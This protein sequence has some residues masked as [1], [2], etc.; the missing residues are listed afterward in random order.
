MFHPAPFLN[1]QYSNAKS[2]FEKRCWINPA[3]FDY[4]LPKD[5][6]AFEPANPRDSARLFVYDTAT[7]T[8]TQ[9]TFLSLPEFLPRDSFLVMNET[10]VLPARVCLS[11]AAGK[12]VNVLFLLNE[13]CEQGI[14]HG[15]VDRKLN[16]GKKVWADEAYAFEVTAH[17]GSIFSFR[18]LFAFEKLSEFFTR[19]GSTPIPPYLQPSTLLEA[20]LRERYQTV[21]ARRDGSIA[22][23]TAS[24]HFTERVFKKCD[25]L[26]IP[27]SLLTLHVGRGTFAPLT[28]EQLASGRLHEEWYEISSNTVEQLRQFKAEGRSLTAVGTTSV[29]SL[30]SF[31]KSGNLKGATDLFI[32]PGFEFQMVDSLI[33]NFHVPKSS[34]MMLVQA[35]LQHK[36]AKR[37]ILQLYEV[38]IAEK[39]RFYSFGDSML[40]L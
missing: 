17:E 9:S 5:L 12:P 2:F 32:R 21:F 7:D 15:L 13:P 6:L 26:S 35:F 22:A 4:E 39:F 40:L 36:K 33:T 16:V 38:A 10:R 19:F 31:A 24:L 20:D 18:P 11:K 34:L 27:R 3:D 28:G 8:I 1:S 14:L 23:P 30:E 25:Q 29:R 37:N